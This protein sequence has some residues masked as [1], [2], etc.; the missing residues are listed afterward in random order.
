MA[1]E[2]PHNAHRGVVEIVEGYGPG[3]RREQV[4]HPPS[5]QQRRQVGARS[6]DVAQGLCRFLGGGISIDRA[7][8][9][10]WP[11]LQRA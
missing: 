5:S 8:Q 2:A 6:G 1:L 11:L 4:R 10:C 9:R 7:R 3:R